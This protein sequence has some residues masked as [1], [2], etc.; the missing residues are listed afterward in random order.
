[1]LQCYKEIRSSF[2]KLYVK[3]SLNTTLVWCI[4]EKN[5]ALDDGLVS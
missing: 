4:A 3:G 1:M 5:D 2:N